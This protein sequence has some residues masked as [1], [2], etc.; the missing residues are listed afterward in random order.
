MI[1]LTGAMAA[2]SQIL[3]LPMQINSMLFNRR[4]VLLRPTMWNT[5]NSVVNCIEY[6]FHGR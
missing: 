5:R 3:Y 2:T 4:P 1:N 6:F